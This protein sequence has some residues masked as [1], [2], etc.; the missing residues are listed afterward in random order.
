MRGNWLF[1]RSTTLSGEGLETGPL[2]S[3]ITTHLPQASV[4]CVHTR[5]PGMRQW[6]QQWPTHRLATSA[7]DADVSAQIY[8]AAVFSDQITVHVVDTENAFQ[9]HSCTVSFEGSGV[10]Y[11]QWN[12]FS[13]A[14]KHLRHSA[15]SES[16]VLTTEPRRSTAAHCGVIDRHN[17]HRYQNSH[18]FSSCRRPQHSNICCAGLCQMPGRL[19]KGIVTKY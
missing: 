15:W 18:R 6:H 2:L 5:G 17:T 11:I 16:I 19:H 1:T 8:I 3:K 14:R 12:F 9:R 7:L 13:G 10:L 4:N